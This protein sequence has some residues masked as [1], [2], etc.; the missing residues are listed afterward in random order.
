MSNEKGTQAQLCHSWGTPLDLQLTPP[1]YACTCGSISERGSQSLGSTVP[2]A[3][4]DRKGA[5]AMS[6]DLDTLEHWYPACRSSSEMDFFRI[7]MAC[8]DKSSVFSS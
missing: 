3:A 8:G 6:I 4:D 5:I 2:C 7:L 1:F